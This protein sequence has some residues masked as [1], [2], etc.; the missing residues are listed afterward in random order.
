MTDPL[1]RN[2]VT[3]AGK[4]DAAQTLLFV[5]GFGTDQTAWA[6]VAGAFAADYRLVLLDNVGAGRSDPEAFVQVRYLN[7]RGYARDLLDVCEALDLQDAVLI[8]HSVGAMIGALAAIEAPRRIAKLVMIGGSP[9]YLDDRDYHGGF[10]RAGLDQLYAEVT[11]SYAGWAKS[12]API[13]MGN[14][15]RPHLAGYFADSLQTVPAAHALTILCS[16]FQSD[17]RADLARITQPTLIVQSTE[18]AAVPRAVA[19]YLRDHIR[20]GRL[21]IIEATGHLPHV[22]APAEVVAAIADFV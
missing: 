8:G 6:E 9:R 10:T 13:A 7:L 22:S 2:H 11:R 15:D 19:E 20:G 1:R 21:S 3:I 14:P 16:I 12:F 18:D 17:H 4:R 5:H